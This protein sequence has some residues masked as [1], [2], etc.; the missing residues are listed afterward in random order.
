MA[1]IVN[2]IFSGNNKNMQLQLAYS[3]TQ[4]ADKNQSTITMTLRV[5]KLTSYAKS[6][7][8]QTPYTLSVNGSTVKSS[9]MSFDI[10]NV[11]VGG[12][13][14]VATY[15]NTYNH[16]SDG[17]LSLSL[18]ATIDLSGTD[19]GR[20]SVST[21]VTLADIPKNSYL[22]LNK[23]NYFLGD[24]LDV[25]I[26]S[27]DSTFYHK[28]RVY[29]NDDESYSNTYNISAG[30]TAVNYQ[31][32]TSWINST[33]FK[34]STSADC[35]LEVSTYRD[36]NYSNQVGTA[37]DVL[38]T[39][40]V[41]TSSSDIN[42]YFTFSV[43]SLSIVSVD[44]TSYKSYLLNKTK[45]KI[46]NISVKSNTSSAIKY[47]KITGSDGYNSGLLTYSNNMSHTTSTLT[48]TGSIK[49]TITITDSRGITASYTNA[50]MSINVI[51]YSL[52]VFKNVVTSR[53]DQVDGLYQDSDDGGIIKSIIDFKYF[54]ED[55]SN[56]LSKL[57]MSLTDKS[58]TT[59]TKSFVY[60]SNNTFIDSDNASY[61]YS[62]YKNDDTYYYT[63]YW[64]ADL[65]QDESYT[66]TYKLIDSYGFATYSDE[67]SSAF[68]ILDIAPNGKSIAIGKSAEEDSSGLEISMPKIQFS[69][70]NKRYLFNST[71]LY[72][73]NE[74]VKMILQKHDA[75]STTA[76]VNLNNQSCYYT[77]KNP[78]TSL[79][80]LV[81]G[82][83]TNNSFT[84]NKVNFST[85]ST[86]SMSSSDDIYYA[87]TDCN[88]GTITPQPSMFYSIE[89]EYAFNKVLGKV[90]GMPI[91]INSS[92]GGS[93]GGG[94]TTVVEVQDGPEPFSKVSELVTLAKGYY[95][96]AKSQNCFEYGTN[97]ILSLNATQTN[98]KCSSSSCSNKEL[99]GTSGP[100]NRFYINGNTLVGLCLRG[101]AYSNSRFN[102]WSN[103]SEFLPNSYDWAMDLRDTLSIDS[104]NGGI[105]SAA[106][107]AKYCSDK[108]WMIDKCWHI[109]N[110]TKLKAGDLIFWD[111]DDIDNG[112]WNNISRVGICLGTE[113]IDS[114]DFAKKYPNE[115]AA[116]N[117]DMMVL[118]V[119]DE[120]NY[121]GTHYGIRTVKLK[122][123]SPDK[124]VHV[125]RIQY[126]PYAICTVSNSAGANLRTGP[127][128]T[129]NSSGQYVYS[130]ITNVA[131]GTTL[132]IVDQT[133]GRSKIWYK[134]LYE[135][136]N[137][138]TAW[139]SSAIVTNVT[140]IPD[141]S[142][143]DDNT[144]SDTTDFTVP[145]YGMDISKHQGTMNFKSVKDGDS[146]KFAILRMGYGNRSG[147]SPAM[148]P[149]FTE[150]LNGCIANKIPV[151]VYFFSYANSV[152]AAQA[153]AKWVV[154]Q[155]AKY[156][157]TF[158]FPI[159]FDQEYDSLKTVYNSSTGTYT[160]YNP[161][162]ATLTS[163]MNAFC[164]IINDAGYM[165][166]IYANP[167]WF[168]NYV[169]FSD[170]Q[171]KD[172]IWIAQWT[173]SLTWN[174]ADVKIWQTGTSKITGYSGEVDYDKCLFNYPQHVRNNH[175][176][177]F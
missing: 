141:D 87:G 40:N 100:H 71:G 108:R 125:A 161:G 54:T 68:F 48:T 61:V 64:N 98:S 120:Q 148:D 132:Q 97:T 72:V 41:S 158:E 115:T 57:Q 133:N 6:W 46:S 86:F 166:G 105:R 20:G 130:V 168:A 33:V 123:S 159:F 62:G 63:L 146:V 157:K 88:N 175:L 2:G 155:L 89:Y 14:T 164:K 129:I 176:H 135:S 131:N 119:V 140:E 165:A 93:T 134:V 25:T 80:V 99:I 32:P 142:G 5:K 7:K 104:S 11:S 96:Q 102:S 177:G 122:D 76:A 1:Y 78:L 173:S 3:C 127:S 81:S 73:D 27:S 58:G 111:D 50:S 28:V 151:G 44:S 147:T 118:E 24:N 150:Y 38:C 43:G 34:N 52:P 107:I 92:G 149:K 145:C 75:T 69:F 9:I 167:D 37:I 31:I 51:E 12:Y 53:A 77:F 18:G 103:D 101:I 65:K 15:T 26:A 23:D 90:V 79:R 112:E 116:S 144:S 114:T 82:D 169:N 19:P 156:P 36:S 94:G 55:S 30:V 172:H 74:I 84:C 17:S 70:N 154:K 138:R 136:T 10:R 153:E 174:K 160:E 91:T 106:E 60:Q 16:K 163:Y 59:I 21:T 170:V 137:R 110:Y 22:I 45:C 95:S 47:I 49:Y 4:D 128:S 29:L 126:K 8:R 42:S 109:T 13:V 121:S 83:P 152:A 162:K 143:S 85:D 35:C 124:V 39:V 66:I 56:K 117:S 113:V 139:V 67:I 171:Y